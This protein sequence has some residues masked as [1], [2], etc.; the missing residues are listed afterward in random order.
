MGRDTHIGKVKEEFERVATTFGERTAGRFDHMKVVEFSR[1]SPGES[2]VEVGAGT[3]NFLALFREV[4]ALLAAVDVTHSMLESARKLHGIENLI[5]ADGAQLPLRDSSFSLVCCAQM[6]HH[7]P[8]PMPL[9]REMAR[10]AGPG[11]RVLVVD[12]LAG[13]SEAEIEALNELEILRD[14]SHAR[15]RPATEFRKLLTQV[16]LQIVDEKVTERKESFSSWMS[17]P[18]F[19]PERIEAVRRYI[20]DK[21]EATGLGF[22]EEGDEIFYTRRRIM[23]LARLES[24]SRRG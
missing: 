16:G 14:P 10:V 1:I 7:V 6:L 18:E 5:V 4:A 8:D 21:G 17:P 24:A 12:Q 20:S 11:G 13:D 9:L 19:P 23:L 3:G 15:S 22:I 2:V